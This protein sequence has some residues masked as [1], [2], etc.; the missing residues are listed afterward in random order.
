MAG[1]KAGAFEKARMAAS[2]EGANGEAR[3]AIGKQGGGDAEKTCTGKHGLQDGLP[4]FCE[5][6]VFQPVEEFCGRHRLGGLNAEQRFADAKGRK[7]DE[8][9]GQWIG[10]GG[11]ERCRKQVAGHQIGERQSEDGMEADER[12]E[13]RKGAGRNTRGHRMRRGGQAQD[14]LGK[15]ARRTRE[16][17]ARPEEFAQSV[18]PA[19]LLSAS[20]QHGP[21]IADPLVAFQWR[22]QGTMSAAAVA[23][24]GATRIRG[25]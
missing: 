13:G 7:R 21:D 10:K 19:G 24:E 1:L 8:R 25:T 18:R 9:N 22:L 23:P 3:D 12:R 17:F 5:L 2:L 4:E 20:E 6:Q 14:P 11:G 15:V 16:A